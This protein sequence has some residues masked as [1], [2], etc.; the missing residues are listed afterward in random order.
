MPPR[1]IKDKEK[2]EKAVTRAPRATRSLPLAIWPS[3]RQSATKEHVLLAAIDR[4]EAAAQSALSRKSPVL[5][6]S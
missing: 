1:R 5:G 3:P 6:Q 4:Q 2:S